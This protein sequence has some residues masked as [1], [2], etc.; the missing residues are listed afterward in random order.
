MNP[1]KARITVLD[2]IILSVLAL[3]AGFIVYRVHVGLHYRWNWAVIPRYLFRYD[4]ETSRWVPNLLV[5]GFLMTIRL[6]IWS[7]LAAIVIG[8]FMGI[9]RTSE[10]R[11]RRM[12]GTAYVELIRNTPPLVLMF[13]FY[14]FI[15]NQIMAALQV[16]ELIRSSPEGVKQTASFLF[17]KPSS[18]PA[19]FSA[20]ITLALYE[21][22][23]ITEIV[24]A[25]ILS[26]EKGQWESAYALGLSWRQQMQFVI[27]PQAFQRILPALAGQFISAIKDSAI[28]SVISIQD[29]TFQ[30]MELMAATY[31]TF[32]VWITIALM[33]FA[34]TF[35]CSL[36]VGRIERRLGRR[37]GS[38]ALHY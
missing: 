12:I 33:Y 18:L 38:V 30:G 35:S 22:A 8:T 11:F 28:V 21:G 26:I 1:G 27:L 16:D 9:L 13:I 3:L 7:T 17:D 25:G 23:Y 6:S 31:R 34:L 14:F 15:G 5:N 37:T 10:N 2:G 24:R 29:L 4:I 36:I 20:L 19:F 32:E